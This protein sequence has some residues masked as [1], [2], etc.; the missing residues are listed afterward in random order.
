MLFPTIIT[1]IS[2]LRS[3][4]RRNRLERTEVGVEVIGV[5]FD[6]L[7]NEKDGLW[8]EATLLQQC[9]ELF[10]AI[11]RKSRCVAKVGRVLLSAFDCS[12]VISD[13]DQRE[14]ARLHQLI[15]DSTDAFAIGFAGYYFEDVG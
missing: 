1:A 15:R 9:P 2:S 7:W 12:I 6:P 4:R 14:A 11:R 5:G 8:L 10:D 13:L 3:L